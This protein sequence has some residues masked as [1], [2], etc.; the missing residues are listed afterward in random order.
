M[1]LLFEKGI[2]GGMCNVIHKY[3][4]ANNKYLKNYDATKKYIFIVYLD[5][6]NLYGWGMSNNL[7]LESF[8]WETVLSIITDDFIKNY[9]EKSY[10]GYL[11]YAD[12]AYPKN[13]YE[14]HKDLSFLPDR[15]KVNK[16]NKPTA[17]I[18]DKNNYSIHI[19]AL[20]QALNHGLIFKKVHNA[21]SFRHSAW[22]KP[23][24]DM[25]TKL[26]TKAKK[27][28][29]K[30]YFKS[31]NNAAYGKTM[32]NIRKHR[33]I[34][35]VDND[36]KRKVLASKPN[37]HAAKHISKDLLIM[38]MKKR[39]LY[40]NKPIYLGQTILDISKT[41]MYLMY[42]FWYDYIRPKYEDKVKLCYM[43]TDS[44]V[45]MIETEDFFKDINSDVDKWFDTSNF[46]KNDDR[47]L[48]IGKNKKVIG[49]FKDELGGKIISEFCALKAKTYAYKLDNGNEVKKA[50]DT[51]KCVVKS[52]ISFSNNV[53]ILFNSSKL[54]KSQFTFKSDHHDIYTQKI[55]KIAL[56]YF[57]DK[58]IQVDDKITTY[59]YGCFEN[60][61]N[62]NS[63]IKNNTDKLNENYN[64]KDPLKKENTNVTLDINEIIDVNTDIYADSAK[65]AFIDNIKGTIVNYLTSIRSF[66]ND[67]IKRACEEIIKSYIIYADSAKS[68]CNDITKSTTIYADSAKSTCNDIIKRTNIKINKKNTNVTRVYYKIINNKSAHSKINYELNALSKLKKVRDN[69]IIIKKKLKPQVINIK[70]ELNGLLK[71]EKVTNA[72]NNLIAFLNKHITQIIK[73]NKVHTHD[74]INSTTH[75]YSYT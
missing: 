70:Y 61:M 58:R 35:L 41:L 46:D 13:L 42:E 37:Y 9:D 20:K 60:N 21:I 38:E 11:F 1:L 47:P 71:L 52:H 15:M 67:I 55:N 23:Y 62:I 6:N 33:D 34:R 74:K 8:K 72:S 14:L 39:E 26:R 53:D 25:N 59:P 7:P 56:N 44:F 30:D 27:G 17:S 36:K 12:I 29:E 4:K 51:K 45:M 10:I 24:I 5:A 63:E 40:M 66:C 32:E 50:K 22:L 75:A 3:A 68:T 16:V 43:D 57:D 54:L 31:K 73:G 64:T 19:Y 28:F 49:K 2:R 65:S 18:Y 48:L 69:N